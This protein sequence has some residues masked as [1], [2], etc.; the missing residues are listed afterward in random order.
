M[1]PLND[2]QIEQLRTHLRAMLR[3][4]ES[5]GESE[6]QPEVPETVAKEVQRKIAAKKC[7]QC[8]KVKDERYRCGCC[9]NCYMKSR[10]LI[11]EGKVTERAMVEHGLWVVGTPPGRKRTPTALDKLL[12]EGAKEP[13]QE[14]LD[15][16]TEGVLKEVEGKKKKRKG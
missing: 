16:A 7:L 10:R 11:R 12:I 5:A 13:T 8:G 1:A 9:D 4:L 15:A 2:D 3:V 6:P 14:K